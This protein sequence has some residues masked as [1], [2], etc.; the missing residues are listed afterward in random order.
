KLKNLQ[1]RIRGKDLIKIGFKPSIEFRDILEQI[2]K[3][4]LEGNL[5]TYEDEI[6][7]AKKIFEM[8]GEKVC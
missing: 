7:Y 8:K 4:V 1:L 2:K 3:E 5:K 6:N